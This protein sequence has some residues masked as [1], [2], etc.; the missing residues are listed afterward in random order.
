MDVHSCSDFNQATKGAWLSCRV[1]QFSGF[2]CKLAKGWNWKKDMCDLL[3]SFSC[4][5]IYTAHAWST[6]IQVLQ[7]TSFSFVIGCTCAKLNDL[8]RARKTNRQTIDRSHWRWEY[9]V[10]A[11]RSVFKC[12]CVRLVR[13][14]NGSENSIRRTKKMDQQFQME[15]AEVTHARAQQYFTPNFL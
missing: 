14:K 1:C 2:L 10:P 3:F 8:Y 7:V 12:V 5:Y 9:S 15:F 6:N 4:P 13:K 11:K